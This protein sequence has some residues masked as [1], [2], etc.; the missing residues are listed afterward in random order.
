MP[1]HETLDRT[2]SADTSAAPAH[3]RGG[4]ASPADPER[5]CIL[6]GAHAPRDALLRL[7]LSPDGEVLPDIFAK[8]PG[9]GAWVVPDRAAITGAIVQKRL[10]KALARA[11]KTGAVRFP[12]DLPD[13]IE[14]GLRRASLDRLGLEARAGNLILGFD[15]IGDA[16]A[17][18]RV[19]LLLHASDAGADGIA[20]LDGRL[21]AAG[22]GS[23]IVLP[24]DRAEISV[25]V[26]RENVVHAALGDP[27][28]A[29]RVA[30]LVRRWRDFL[31]LN[32]RTL[33]RDDDTRTGVGAV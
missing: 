30:A 31:G 3:G 1:E 23:A 26:G 2:P 7:A 21:R 13:R 19:A 6:T 14:S 8:A 15:R 4:K 18:G 24:A 28:A 33:G 22:K 10:S 9:R 29:R 20:K 16:I 11:F 5:R 17:A 25:A 32:E 27:G 12:D